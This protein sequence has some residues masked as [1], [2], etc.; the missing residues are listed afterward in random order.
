MQNAAKKLA[1]AVLQKAVEKAGHHVMNAIHD[2]ASQVK[3][4]KK[5]LKQTEHDGNRIDNHDDGGA[6]PMDIDAD[7][8]NNN[9]ERK[10]VTGKQHHELHS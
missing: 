5:R 4:H 2:A 3:P 6:K 9:N 7:D 10:I 8:N 1:G